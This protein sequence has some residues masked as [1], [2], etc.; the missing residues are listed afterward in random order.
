VVP[1][2][3]TALDLG[4]GVGR[5]SQELAWRGHDVLGVDLS[6]SMIEQARQRADRDGVR[7]TFEVGDVVNLALG[8][9]FDVI[10]CVTVL[11]HV[12]DPTA[13]R[14]AVEKLAAH[15]APDG[16]LILLEAAPT[17]TSTRCDTAV[18]RARR[19]E[20]YLEA[21]DQA[22]LSVTTVAGVDPAPFKLWLLPSYRRLP[23]LLAPLA[24]AFVTALSLP[25]DWLLCQWLP[26]FSWHKVLIVRHRSAKAA[27]P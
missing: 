17:R 3:S 27:S 2:T 7:C 18:F 9:Q 26:Q 16:T 10:V 1:G 8:R 4:C 5:W 22:G 14:T 12:L 19:L 21:L 11:Q 15:L 23:A 13:A 25:F 24:L 20:W 6:P